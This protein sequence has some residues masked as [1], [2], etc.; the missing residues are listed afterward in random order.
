MLGLVV[1][2]RV[3][4]RAGKRCNVSV[5]VLFRLSDEI[6]NELVAEVEKE[7]DDMCNEYV[8]RVYKDEFVKN[9]STHSEIS[10][11]SDRL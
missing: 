5:T 6:V 8:E 11:S 2:R 9:E 1:C 4:A 7:L 10:V 3:C